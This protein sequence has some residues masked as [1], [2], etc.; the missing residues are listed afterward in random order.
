MPDKKTI[1]IV[2]GMGPLATADL[3][4]KIILNTAAETD[5]DHIHIIVD[6]NTNIPDRTSAILYGGPDPLPEIKKSAETLKTMGADF[7]LLP[8]N[9]VHY[10]YDR[11]AATI[12]IP[13]LN[14]L[15][16]TC[17]AISARGIKT[18]GLLA[19][20]ST[21]KTGI[22]QKRCDQYGIRMN[23][24]DD[25]FQQE[26]VE[27]ITRG[28]KAGCKEYDCTEI[29]RKAWKMIGE[30]AEIIVLGCTELPVAYSM[31][32]MDF[33]SLDPTYELAKAAILFAG[34]KVR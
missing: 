32:H 7:I 5:R 20:T 19:T 27:L 6:N 9:A 25:L 10:Y 28:I 26:I 8:C 13:V 11:I 30:G 4:S 24:P 33:P 18:I 15:D 2:G 22:Y 31:Y 23:I 16:I 17:K 1:G 14:M 3:F 12:D 21:I 34:Y 29:N